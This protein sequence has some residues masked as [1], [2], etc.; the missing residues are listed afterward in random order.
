MT[1][2]F[3]KLFERS[4]W[5]GDYFNDNLPKKFFINPLCTFKG[6]WKTPKIHNKIVGFKSKV[7]KDQMD[8]L[9]Q[10]HNN[11]YCAGELDLIKDKD[12]IK[13]V[14]ALGLDEVKVRSQIQKPTQMHLIHM[15]NG[16]TYEF[17]D[18]NLKKI[19]RVFIMLDDW[20]P[21]QVIIFG[22]NHVY[23]WKRG[24]VI[25]FD[26]FNIPHGTANFGHNDRPMLLVTGKTTTYFEKLLKNPGK[27]LKI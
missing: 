6:K 7:A 16:S 26:W 14:N 27:I 18:P 1:K 3:K 21:G 20:H 9:G 10:S 2:I 25:Y 15:D 8:A 13:M 24:D 12:L 23:K 5:N 11:V 4:K 19:K 22:G 17:D